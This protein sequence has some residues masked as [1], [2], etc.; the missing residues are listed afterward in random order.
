MLDGLVWRVR[1][2]RW[3][4]VYT[5]SARGTVSW[6]DPFNGM[7]GNGN[8]RIEKDKLITRWSASKTWE[9]W[10]LPIN[11]RSASGQ[12]HMDGTTYD[13]WAEAE[14]FYLQPGDV[15]TVAG[16]KYVIYPD[17]VRSLGKNGT[18]AWVCRNPGN[19]R[20][21][22]K[23]RAYKGKKFHTTSAGA[24]AIFPDEDTAMRAII[25]VLRGY[26]HVTITRAMNR[27]APPGDGANDPDQYG[28][29][30]A[31]R[32]GVSVDTFVDTLDD[33][34]L[35]TFADQIKTV[36]GWRPGDVFSRDDENL[37]G[38]VRQRLGPHFYP[39]TAEEIR[40]SSLS[41]PW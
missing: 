26:G 17:E 35:E 38:E 25:S 33:T 14:N 19:I 39:P 10:D 1:V 40:N 27:Y 23:Y 34:Q 7:H 18:V 24:F 12:C 16:K 29:I 15:V 3:T 36:E 32:L 37:P 8:W 4:W 13:L 21:G 2:D 28:R 5:F 31:K 6:R 11:P 22:D 20:D 9:E 30:V 41:Q